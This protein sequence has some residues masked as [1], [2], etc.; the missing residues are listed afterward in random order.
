MF[1]IGLVGTHFGVSER[2]GSSFVCLARFTQEISER[3]GNELYAR[4]PRR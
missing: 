3:G 4:N 1:Y 2:L